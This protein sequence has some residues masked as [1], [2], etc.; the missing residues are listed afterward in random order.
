[1][2]WAFDLIQLHVAVGVITNTQNQILVARRP[3]HVDQGN[4]WE[5]PGG[6]VDNG[7]T[8]YDALCRELKEE[9]N[10]DVL[11]A[12]PFLKVNHDYPKH[13]VLLDTWRVEKYSGDVQGAEGQVIRWVSLKELKTLS[14]PAGSKLIIDALE[15]AIFI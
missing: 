13:S 2:S 12:T 14:I 5:F 10:L 8:V 15:S 3:V 9:L 6:K 1:V 4:L 7:E 11:S